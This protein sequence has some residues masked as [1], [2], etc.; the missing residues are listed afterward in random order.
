MSATAPRSAPEP[1][2]PEISLFVGGE[3]TRSLSDWRWLWS[4]DVEFPIRSHRG[5]LG[6][7]IVGFKRLVRPL[8]RAP[9]SDLWERQRVFNLI[10]LEGL[11][12]SADLARLVADLELRIAAAHERLDGQEE[13]MRQGLHEVMI[14]TDALFARVDQ[15][16]DG[17]RR[18]VRDQ[19]ATLGA[20]LA[21]A[22]APAAGQ[23]PATLVAA[24]TLVAADRE[25]RY[26]VF[27]DQY[28]GTADEIRERVA[29]YLPRLQG[30]SP[31]LDLGCGRGEALQVFGAAGLTARGVDASEEMVRQCRE[32]GLDAVVGDAISTLAATPAAILGAVVS[33][34]VIEHLPAVEVDRLLGL[35]WKAL[36]PGGLLILETPDARSLVVGGS[37]FWIDPTHRR[38]VHPEALRHRCLAAGFGTAELIAMHPFPPGRTL[39]AIDLSDL[40]TELQPLA[41][42]VNRLRDRLDDLLFGDQD[43][44]V[45]ATKK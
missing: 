38:P 23:A 21:L 37:N 19:A 35:A 13:L 41:D 22:D 40:A 7:L 43:Y 36:A 4:Q 2:A 15:K 18:Q 8:V 34:H 31:I 1:R 42:R 44:A 20:A 39:P 29:V 10:L 33:L 25:L 3:P 17:Y 14:H 30:R 5:W 6:S 16:L 45:L 12:R 11:E 9:Q 27:E 28:R 32:L 26:R 24:E